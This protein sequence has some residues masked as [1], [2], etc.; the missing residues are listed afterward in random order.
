MSTEWLNN[1][2]WNAINGYVMAVKN[3]LAATRLNRLTP[4][5][6][7]KREVTLA[8]LREELQALT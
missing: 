8:E 3:N 5:R 4:D 1:L 7:L 2:R 6:I